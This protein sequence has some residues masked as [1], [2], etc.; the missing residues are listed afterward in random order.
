MALSNEDRAYVVE[1]ACDMLKH[2]HRGRL[3][4]I[5]EDRLKSSDG[6]EDERER[7]LDRVVLVIARVIDDELAEPS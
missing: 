5:L 1:T 6:Y 7:E 3:V 2:R 4:E